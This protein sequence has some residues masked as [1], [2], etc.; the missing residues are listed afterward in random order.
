MIIINSIKIIDKPIYFTDEKGNIIHDKP[1]YYLLSKNKISKS[2][3]HCSDTAV[4]N[5]DAI[6]FITPTII[7]LSMK[8][9][10]VQ[11]LNTTLYLYPIVDILDKI[12]DTILS[13]EASNT[14]E[15]PVNKTEFDFNDVMTFNI[16]YINLGTTGIYC[17]ESVEE[18]YNKKL[19]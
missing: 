10:T 14:S 12:D 4:I 18:I 9:I 19:N 13:R 16:S 3:N 8:Y 15:E 5:Q 11:D 2:L 1:E 6:L 7:H 17:I